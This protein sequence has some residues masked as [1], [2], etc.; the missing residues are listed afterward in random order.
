MKLEPPVVVINLAFLFFKNFFHEYSP[1]NLYAK[2][3]RKVLSKKP[4]NIAG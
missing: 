1:V 2:F 3:G 4:F